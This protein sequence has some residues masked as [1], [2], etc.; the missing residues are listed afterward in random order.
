MD[1]FLEGLSGIHL[2]YIFLAFVVVVVCVVISNNPAALLMSIP[3]CLL[4]SVIGHMILLNEK[5]DAWSKISESHGYIIDYY[6]ECRESGLFDSGSKLE[7]STLA[8][9]ALSENRSMSKE[10]ATS[11]IHYWE[12][13]LSI[14]SQFDSGN[15]Q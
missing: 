2:P 5:R 7:C 4:L 8:I 12:N 15:I 3:I 1:L 10:K 13:N 9:Q 6:Q 14:S 11:L